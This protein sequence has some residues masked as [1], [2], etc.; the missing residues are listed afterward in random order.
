MLELYAGSRW[1]I[2]RLLLHITF[3]LP[4]MYLWYVVVGSKMYAG[5]FCFG[6]FFAYIALICAQLKKP[7]LA[8]HDD[9]LEVNNFF[10]MGNKRVSLSKVRSVNARNK[11]IIF[12]FD[13]ERIVVNLFGISSEKIQE[14]ILN[15]SRIIES[16]LG[17]TVTGNR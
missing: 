5:I 17:I 3:I 15:L 7:L 11:F 2:L 8:L 10:Y 9:F 14:C 16:R 6:L 13:S 12:H 4:M 1:I